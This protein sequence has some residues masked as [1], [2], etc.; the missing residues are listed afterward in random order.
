MK[1]TLKNIILLNI[2][3][4]LNSFAS[5]ASFSE[6][7][8]NLEKEVK[9]IGISEQVYNNTL[10]HIKEVNKKVLKLYDNQPEFKITFD[11]YY[12]RNIN[13]KRIELGKSLLKKHKKIL[14]EIYLKYKVPPRIIVSIWGIETNYGSYM[15]NFNVIEALATLAYASKRKKFFKKELINS[16]LIYEK[17]YKNSDKIMM[18]SWA[19]AMGQ[20]QFMPSSFI[21]YAVDYDNDG[22]IDIWNSK[23]D[24]FAS[25]ANYLKQHGWKEKIH[26][27]N[28]IKLKEK[29]DKDG[30]YNVSI[31]SDIRKLNN[32][33]NSKKIN[34]KIIKNNPYKRFFSINENFHTIKKYNNSDYYALIIGVLANKIEYED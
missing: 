6:W 27:C 13:L 15:G 31:L 19:G 34:I 20:S 32:H 4:L 11:D 10:G 5:S 21:N 33:K 18:G 25:I 3:F 23:K 28:E 14:Q 1:F 30:Y 29:I 16:L 17:Y 26:W 12:N 7:I 9:N 8:K 22:L 2:I 24:V